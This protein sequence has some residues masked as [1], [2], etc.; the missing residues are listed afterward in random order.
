MP[1]RWGGGEMNGP[2]YTGASL[3]YLKYKFLFK[4][5]AIPACDRHVDNQHV[6]NLSRIFPNYKTRR[7]V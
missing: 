6:T 7:L 3:F 1:A 5:G 2:E 4:K